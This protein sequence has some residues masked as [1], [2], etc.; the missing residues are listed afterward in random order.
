MELKGGKPRLFEEKLI[1]P[2]ICILFFETFFSDFS[3]VPLQ[4]DGTLG[5]A[6][7]VS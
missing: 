5:G 6:P 1:A 3:D 4:L 2:Y 7:I